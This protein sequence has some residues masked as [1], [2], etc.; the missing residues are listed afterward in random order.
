MHIRTS[1]FIALAF[2]IGL[3]SALLALEIALRFLPVRE[4]LDV[5]PVTQQNPYLHFRPN[6][7][8]VHSVGW[9]FS[10]VNRV[11]VN[12]YG[13]VN[14][15]D[16]DPAQ[17]SP[18]VAVIGDSYV[19]AALL[20]YR[21]TL[22][23][24]LA[25][26]FASHGRVYSFGSSGS[27]LSQYLAYAEFARA[28]FRPDALIV[29]IVSNDFDES[30]LEYKSTRGH[31]YL[32]QDGDG[33]YSLH[34]VPWSPRFGHSVLTGSALLRYVA[35][36]APT[37]MQNL[38][39]LLSGKDDQ[40]VANAPSRVD[41]ERLEKSRKAVDVFL[42]SLPRS[43]GVLPGDIVLVIDGIRPQLYEPPMLEQAR[44]S[45]FGQMREYLI[46]QAQRQ[47]YAIADVQ[48]RFVRRHARDGAR[49]EWDV[50]NHWNSN[51][52]EEAALA[53][54]DTTVLQ[55]VLGAAPVK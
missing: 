50:D 27:A 14:D 33:N 53:V 9:N 22:H 1:L 7:S 17:T 52:H 6:R 46:S 25:A 20:P 41:A 28:Q 29:V 10:I 3:A 2:L 44:S 40:Y 18:L 30:L 35:V 8:V 16:Y 34:L 26:I 39:F 55:R 21:H 54:L 13:F 48:S 47:G 38:R 49:F 51:G 23:G 11:H 19:E 12:N 42:G 37:A 32:K 36:T 24:R 31:H 5:Q 45:Y 4:S 15:Q 43:A